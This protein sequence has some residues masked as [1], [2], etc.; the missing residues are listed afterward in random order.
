[1]KNKFIVRYINN[2]PFHIYQFKK[3]GSDRIYKDKY[4]RLRL[5]F[6]IYFG[7]NLDKYYYN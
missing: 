5:K 7:I 1:M 3:D 6:N 4:K 2:N